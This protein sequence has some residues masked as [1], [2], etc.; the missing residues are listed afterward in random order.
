MKR[1]IFE[2][3]KREMV[4]LLSQFNVVRDPYDGIE[5]YALAV[6]REH[7][8][9]IGVGKNSL[10]FELPR[11]DFNGKKYHLVGKGFK[12]CD[13]T[14]KGVPEDELH[15]VGCIS[16]F[17][18]DPWELDRTVYWLNQMNLGVDMSQIR[19]YEEMFTGKSPNEKK[20]LYFTITLDLREG[21]QYQVGEAEDSLFER[22]SNGE[23]LRKTRDETCRK[24]L[25]E[26]ES[27]KLKI[28]PAGHGSENEPLPALEHMFLIS[29]NGKMRGR[30]VIGDLNHL[31][32]V[33]EGRQFG[34]RPKYIKQDGFVYCGEY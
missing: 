15:L 34:I 20:H 17:G 26:V 10:V 27:R 13:S 2:A 21:E 16:G 9:L 22:L 28:N 4:D 3:G 14:Y 32:I 29:Y 18:M 25:N 19:Q 5:P 23:N 33:E 7:P 11:V 6:P 1:E 30:L 31:S 24:I 12:Y 8:S